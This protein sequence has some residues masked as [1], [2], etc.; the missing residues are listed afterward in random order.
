M[1]DGFESLTGVRVSVLTAGIG[2]A[3][4]AAYVDK[5]PF[6]ERASSVA[7]GALVA[8]YAT[9][10]AQ[11]AVQLFIAINDPD[12]IQNGVAFFLGVTAMTLVRGAIDTTRAFFKGLQ[13]RFDAEYKN[14]PKNGDK[15]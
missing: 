10:F 2:G 6:W 1:L 13:K 3:I 4:V 9:P 8:V 5:G 12:A 11:E 14:D 7:A 15:K